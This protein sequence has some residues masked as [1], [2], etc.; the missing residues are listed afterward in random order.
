[1]EKRCQRVGAPGAGDRMD[2]GMGVPVPACQ[3]A[4]VRVHQGSQEGPV[5]K[6][7]WRQVMWIWR[8]C[9]GRVWGTWRP[10]RNTAVKTREWLTPERSRSDA[11]ARVPVGRDSHPLERV[12]V[13]LT[14]STTS[15]PGLE[16]VMLLLLAQFPKISNGDYLKWEI[17][18]CHRHDAWD[19]HRPGVQS[20]GHYLCD[21][22][23]VTLSL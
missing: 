21:C 7:E 3:P 11:S 12:R 6:S 22:G 5:A 15:T 17:R 20:A 4:L 18:W 2:P 13:L 10:P 23:Q 19:S 1:M 9:S 14:P 8:V 16:S